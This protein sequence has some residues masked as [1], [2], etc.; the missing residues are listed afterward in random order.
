[1]AAKYGEGIGQDIVNLI[2]N[3]GRYGNEEFVAVLSAQYEIISLF[4]QSDALRSIVSLGRHKL[5]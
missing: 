2:M 4:A 1:M 5:Q 3:Y